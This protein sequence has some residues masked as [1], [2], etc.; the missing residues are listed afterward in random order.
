MSN[1]IYLGFGSNLGN[2]IE[3]IEGAILTLQKDGIIFNYKKSSY[4]RT[5][6]IDADGGFYLNCV[7]ESSTD[8]S[9]KELL[10]SILRTE[11]KH[12]RKRY[13]YHNSRTIDIDILLYNTIIIQDQNL[14]IPHPQIQNRSFVREPLL[15]I[16]PEIIIPGIGKLIETLDPNQSIQKISKK[17]LP[18]KGKRAIMGILNI[19]PDSFYDGGKFSAIEQAIPQLHKLLQEGADIIDVGGQSTKPGHT[20]ISPEE[21]IQRLEPVISEIRRLYPE[22]LLSIDTFYPEVIG[23]LRKYNIDIINDVSDTGK[24]NMD[25]IQI[26]KEIG[27]TYIVTS[28]ASNIES[29]LESFSQKEKIMLDFGF[30]DYIFDP[31]F[32]FGKTVEENFTLLSELG[33]LQKLNVPILVGISRKSMIYKSLRITADEALNGTT[34]I[35]TL[36]LQNGAHLLRAHDVKEAKETLNLFERYE[37]NTIHL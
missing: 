21:E 18:W 33:L 11:E 36:A 25:M 4:Y 28:H 32:G 29:I 37:N 24:L 19:T 20:T 12:G 15:E 34:V 10:A 26:A 6:P 22:I 13:R 8:L 14:K 16:N 17:Q 9:S 23:R 2:R 3:H 1:T 30:K 35:H 31:G 7:I 5:E 27:A